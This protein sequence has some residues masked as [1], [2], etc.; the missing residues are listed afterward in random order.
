MYDAEVLATGHDQPQCFS[1]SFRNVYVYSLVILGWSV[2]QASDLDLEMSNAFIV[3]RGPVKD[4]LYSFFEG[5]VN[6]Q[7]R[8][9]VCLKSIF[10]FVFFLCGLPVGKSL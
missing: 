8:E 1:S 2:Y 5:L 3:T 4:V 7:A 10:I 6:R 9:N